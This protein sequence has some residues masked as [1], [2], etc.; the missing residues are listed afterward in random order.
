[1]LHGHTLRSYYV[2]LICSSLISVPDTSLN[3]VEFGWNLVDS[4]LM[5]N[6]CFVTLPEMYT[7]TCGCK[8]K[9]IERYQWSKFGV[10]CTE[11]CATEKNVAPKFTNNFS[12][13]L[14]KICKYKCFLRA[15]FPRIWTE[16]KDT[17]TRKICGSKSASAYHFWY[18]QGFFVKFIAYNYSLFFV[19]VSIDVKREINIR[20]EI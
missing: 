15:K 18:E 19:F 20:I 1:M 14:H 4:E 2:V 3:P 9:F 12:W 11:F 10:P 5:P 17:Y 13:T 7:G 16:S 6:K 8:K